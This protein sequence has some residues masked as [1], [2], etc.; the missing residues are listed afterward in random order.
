M[1]YNHD[2]VRVRVS[3]GFMFS[4]LRREKKS[5]I[6]RVS[7]FIFFYEPIMLYRRYPHRKLSILVHLSVAPEVPISHH[8]VIVISISNRT[9]SVS[10]SLN[11]GNGYLFIIYNKNQVS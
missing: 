6:G 1:I 11:N 2:R 5:K 8:V 4:T 7:C 10:L 3:R 9:V